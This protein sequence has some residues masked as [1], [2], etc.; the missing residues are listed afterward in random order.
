MASRSNA[1]ASGNGT[2]TSHVGDRPYDVNS[3]GGDAT[4][5]TTFDDAPPMDPP[6]TRNDQVNATERTA[7]L[8]RPAPKHAR[9][10]NAVEETAATTRPWSLKIDF[11]VAILLLLATGYFWSMSIAAVK[12]PFITHTA[13]PPHRGSMFMPIWISFLSCVINTLSLLSFLFPHESPLLSFY[14]SLGSA[15]FALLTLILCVS[16]TQLRIVESV[17]TCVLL[18][19]AIVSSLHAA[20]SASLTDRYAPLLDPPEELDAEVEVGCLASLKRVGKYTLGF[21]GISLPL[22]IGHVAILGAFILLSLN[23]IIRGIDASIEQPGQRWKIDPWLWQRRHFPELGRGLFQSGGREYRV[24]LACRGV[25]LDDPPYGVA[26][27]VNSSVISTLGRPTVRRTILVESEQ[28]IPGAVDAEWLLRMMRQ[29]DLNSGDV[30]TRVCFWDRPGY[31]FSDS[32]P[33]SSN[34]HIVTALSQ[35]LSVS[36]EMARL[37]PPPSFNVDAAAAPSPLARSGFILVSRGHA[38]PI[39]TLFASLHPRL[40]HSFL[41]LAPTAPASVLSRRARS[42]FAVIPTF[43][44][45]TLPALTTELGIKRTWWALKGVG[46]RRRVLAREKEWVS[47]QIERAWVQERFEADR[48]VDSDGAK[49]WEKRRGRYPTR[50][51]VVL[52]GAGEAG[53]GKKFVDEVVGEGLR[54]WDTEWEGG[55]EGCNG[56]EGWE[57]VCR[58]A[59]KEL[60][61]L[62]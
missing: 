28:G 37:E 22:A 44:T 34:P 9:G 18:G 19:L 2:T 7:L 36:G 3:T 16:V 13:L 6:Q 52:G 47:G 32:S 60:L 35:A 1:R 20:L 46:R 33:T 26:S 14:T 51:T 38:T 10:R 8:G 56:G 55:S 24:H 5:V 43:F 45:R 61:A 23:V 29:G 48:G 54:R 15:F 25:G 53:E 31:G 59:V 12:S 30:E 17:L 62:D 42:K 57:K 49:A 41:Y 39:T 40:V 58:E 4:E 50:P 11:V 27:P 21:F